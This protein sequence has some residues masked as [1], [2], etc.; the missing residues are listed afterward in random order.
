ML[1]EINQGTGPSVLVDIGEVM[2]DF[3]VPVY[4]YR[5]FPREAGLTVEQSLAGLGAVGLF[6]EIGVQVPDSLVMDFHS[7]CRPFCPPS[8]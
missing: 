8:F 1:G 7:T 2:G 4:T 3:G 5:N 6:S